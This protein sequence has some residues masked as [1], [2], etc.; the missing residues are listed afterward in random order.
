MTDIANSLGAPYNKVVGLKQLSKD[1][2]EE[3]FVKV[4]KT[5]EEVTNAI[6]KEKN[7]IQNIYIHQIFLS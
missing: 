1:M 7:L 3:E 4:S 2:P 6:K 5:L